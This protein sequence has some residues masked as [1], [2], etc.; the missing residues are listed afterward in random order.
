MLLGSMGKDSADFVYNFE[1][2]VIRTPRITTADSVKFARVIFEDVKDTASCGKHNFKTID[3][4]NLYYDFHLSPK[5]IA[6]G[7]GNVK[8]LPATNRDGLRRENLSIGAFDKK[9]KQ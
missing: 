5:S 1:D 4:D 6:I 8:T 3:E 9:E 7:K 2:C